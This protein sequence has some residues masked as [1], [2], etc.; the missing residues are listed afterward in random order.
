MEVIVMFLIVITGLTAVG[1]A[2]LR[3]G[4]D[5]RGTLPDDH[6]R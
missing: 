5:S 6:A 1:A 3:W 2:S 4:A